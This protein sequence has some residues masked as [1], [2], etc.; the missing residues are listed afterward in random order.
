MDLVKCTLFSTKFMAFTFVMQYFVQLKLVCR[1]E[2][3]VNAE[4]AIRQAIIAGQLTLPTGV[5]R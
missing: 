2:D 1:P 4:N 3:L 5:S